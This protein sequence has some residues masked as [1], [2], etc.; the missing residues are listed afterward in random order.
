MRARVK[1]SV[2]CRDIHQVFTNFHMFHTCSTHVPHMLKSSKVWRLPPIPLQLLH[3][4]RSNSA[5]CANSLNFCNEL[6]V[7]EWL[8]GQN[9]WYPQ[10]HKANVKKF[11]TFPSSLR[12]STHEHLR[13]LTS[14]GDEALIQGITK[15]QND[16]LL[17][18][19][20][21]LPEQKLQSYVQG[22]KGCKGHMPHIWSSV[23][24]C[25]MMFHVSLI[26]SLIRVHSFQWEPLWT[27][28]DSPVVRC[29]QSPQPRKQLGLLSRFE[30]AM[31]T[32]NGEMHGRWWGVQ[33]NCLNETWVWVLNIQR[34]FLDPNGE[35]E[36]QQ[37]QQE[38]EEGI[39][40][41]SPPG[42]PK[43]AT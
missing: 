7:S 43:N 28:C 11:S 19:F 24:W 8:S 27:R 9:R 31:D 10:S 26:I 32:A 33:F 6:L 21:A 18:K 15:A 3:L 17:L 4:E 38:E 14:H 41:Q 39:R 29:L 22:A 20:C 13:P 30:M 5:L 2:R 42:L 23:S 35:P 37:Q 25:F 40:I 16:A 1:D 36:Q 12:Q 34:S